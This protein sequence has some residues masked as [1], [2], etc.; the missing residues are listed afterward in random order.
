MAKVP[1]PWALWFETAIGR[2][3]RPLSAGIGENGF[4]FTIAVDSSSP[5]DPAM[6]AYGLRQLADDPTNCPPDLLRALADMFDPP[7]EH[8]GATLKIARPRGGRNARLD[9]WAIGQEADELAERDGYASAIAAVCA[10]HGC[11]E[12]T[13]KGA[14]TDYRRALSMAGTG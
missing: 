12:T 10:K 13:A 2:R 9:A 7:A 1:M 5:P 3:N 6:M 11:S 14:L 4:H 8:S